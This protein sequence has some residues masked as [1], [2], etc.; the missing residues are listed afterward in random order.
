MNLMFV[1]YGKGLGGAEEIILNLALN[2]NK[3]KYKIFVANLHESGKEKIL[4]KQQVNYVKFFGETEAK[5]VT[6]LKQLI[7]EYKIDLVLSNFCLPGLLAADLTGVRKIEIV[8]GMYI[9]LYRKDRER[10]ISAL[11]KC[12]KIVCVSPLVYDFMVNFFQF[13]GMREKV[14]VIE[15]GV[16]STKLKPT[17]SKIDMREK[18]NI[19]KEGIVIGN[20]GRLTME[21][22]I[23]RVVEIARLLNDRYNNLFFVIPGDHEYYSDY[24]KKIQQKIKRYNLNNIIFPGFI[25]NVADILQI[26]DIFIFLSYLEGFGL[27][28]VEALKMGLPIVTTKVGVGCYDRDLR[29][30]VN[31]YIVSNYSHEFFCEELAQLIDNEDLRKEIGSKNKKVFAKKYLVADMLEK[32]EILFE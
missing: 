23:E 24:Y 14:V 11:K 22:G 15:N 19:P 32:Y 17:I 31:G 5:Q 29:D 30:G 6:S 9:E 12:S 26:Y 27:A 21:K 28:L 10:Y 8:H 7:R 13:S 20:L 4:T 25:E 3:N 18:L 2:L 1:S 16:A